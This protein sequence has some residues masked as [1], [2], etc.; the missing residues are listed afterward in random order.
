MIRFGKQ[1][2]PVWF[3]SWIFDSTPFLKYV[4]LK[5]DCHNDYR[6]ICERI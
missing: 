3:Q 1:L 2:V 4:A 6:K 5:I